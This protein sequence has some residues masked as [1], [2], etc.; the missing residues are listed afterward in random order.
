MMYGS[1]KSAVVLVLFVC[2]SDDVMSV[3][4]RDDLSEFRLHP[5]FTS[6]PMLYYSEGDVDTLKSKAA[7]T[8]KQIAGELERATEYLLAKKSLMPP[9]EEAVFASRWNEVY[10]N[11]LPPLALSYVLNPN[12]SLLTHIKEYMDRMARYKRWQVQSAPKDEVPV[13]HSLVGFTTAFDMLYPYLDDPRRKAYSQKIMEVTQEMSVLARTRPWGKYYL[14]NHQATNVVALLMGSMVSELYTER[15]SAWKQQAL[16]M[17]E[18][19]M[20][21]L[22]GIPDGSLDEGVGYVGYTFRSLSQYVYLLK[23]HM[24][25][26]HT[27]HPWLRKHFQYYYYTILPGFQRTVGIADSPQAWFYGPESQLYFLDAY[28][29]RDGGP[30]WLAKQIKDHKLPFMSTSRPDVQKFATLHTE[31][32]FFDPTVQAHPPANYI[33]SEMFHFTDWGVVTYRSGAID[34]PKSTF[35]SFKSSYLHGKYVYSLANSMTGRSLGG[36]HSFNPGHEHPDQNSFTFWP[37][38]QPFITEGMYGQKM[39]YLDNVLMFQPSNV[40]ACTKPWAGQ[41]GACLKWLIWDGKYNEGESTGEILA[42]AHFNG[43]L[44]TAGDSV[45]AYHKSLGLRHVYRTLLLLNKDLL[46]LVDHVL[47]GDNSTASKPSHSAAFFQNFLYPFSPTEHPNGLSGFKV[48]IPGEGIHRAY[49]TT[50]SAISPPAN[51]RT[52][53]YKASD[54]V[55]HSNA[56][57]TFPLEGDQNA[58]AFLFHGSSVNLQT[59]GIA[60]SERGTDIVLLV[61]TTKHRYRISIPLNFANLW[62]ED[63]MCI[64]KDQNTGEIIHF[65]RWSGVLSMPNGPETNDSSVETTASKQRPDQAA[66]ALV[67]MVCVVVAA[68]L[69]GQKVRRKAWKFYFSLG[70]VLA[71]VVGLLL[72]VV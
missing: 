58:W 25:V 56:N 54:K 16:V 4:F 72:H 6:H 39:P 3:I 24:D 1:A 51:I 57:V 13:A 2:I 70:F 17:Y 23:R 14:Q 29:L 62:K 42:A 31:F 7:T 64:V 28:I 21:L 11:N 53:V 36:W 43:M 18:R 37:N 22:K 20:D 49:W 40:T 41:L 38:G 9:L 44:F 15:A 27:R 66:F 45:G 67:F 32:L 50:T 47:L 71:I 10:G 33:T 61:A 8:H 60:L 65:H 48:D 19:T 68:I 5:R 55:N 63:P 59:F 30:T 46:L 12:A 35:M 34:D 69:L 26:D 52:I